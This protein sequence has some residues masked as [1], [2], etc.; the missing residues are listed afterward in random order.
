MI[1]KGAEFRRDSPESLTAAN[2]LPV[3]VTSG[4]DEADSRDDLAAMVC[5]ASQFG[6]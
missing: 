6:G 4:Q 1:G 5:K 2:T 3:A